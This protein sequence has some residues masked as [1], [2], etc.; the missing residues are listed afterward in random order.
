MATGLETHDAVTADMERIFQPLAGRALVPAFHHDERPRRRGRAGR[1]RRWA[2]YAASAL[3]AL[4]VAALAIGYGITDRSTPGATRIAAAVPPPMSLPT[5]VDV[6]VPS[7]SSTIDERS[8]ATSPATVPSPEGSPAVPS[9]TN[10]P[11]T[12]P[13]RVAAFA[14]VLPRR[15]DEAASGP[16][17]AASIDPVPPARLLRATVPARPEAEPRRVASSPVAIAASRRAARS[18]TAAAA[19][20]CVPGSEDDRCIYQDVL[21]ADARL[22][23]AYDRALQAGTAN[24]WMSAIKRRWVDARYDSLDDPDGTIRRYDRLAAALDNKRRE[25]A[26]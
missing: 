10:R 26:E 18:R 8:N 5:T 7:I 22:R 24:L 3:L 1:A 13:P 15:A 6:P 23:R 25:D 16:R 17:A 11:A 2:P 9:A 19:R 20:P 14:A 21:A 4:I 12:S